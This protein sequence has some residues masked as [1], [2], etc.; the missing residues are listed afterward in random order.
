MQR[1]SDKQRR[2]HDEHLRKETGDLIRGRGPVRA[3]EG[4]AGREEAPE[5]RP[6]PSPRAMSPAE[7]ARRAELTRHLPP[8]VFPAD[9]KR[10]LAHLRSKKAPASVVET[11]SGL[12]EGQEFRTI[13]EIIRAVG[14]RTGG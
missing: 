13:G 14:L 2:A 3:D 7:V 6:E 8:N 5:R 10:L 12:P 11:V 1:E 4:G 9:R